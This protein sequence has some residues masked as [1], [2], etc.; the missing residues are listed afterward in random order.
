MSEHDEFSDEE[1]ED[2]LVSFFM[3]IFEYRCE[4][5]PVDFEETLVLT[6]EVKQYSEAHPCPVCSQMAARLKVNTFAF[7]FAG[8]VTGTS[9]VHGNSGVHDLDYPNLDKCV[10]RS[11]E[12]KWEGI[13]ERQA[14]INKVRKE[15]G[16]NAIT[17]GSDGVPKPMDKKVGEIRQKAIDAFKKSM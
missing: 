15:S 17:V 14:E 5:C 10:G 2:E 12:K 4:V 3:P 11:A 6:S 13:H 1:L 8:G 16:S 9:G 7:K